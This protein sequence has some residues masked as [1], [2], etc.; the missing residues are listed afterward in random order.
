MTITIQ[1]LHCS[2]SNNGACGAHVTTAV[3]LK[4]VPASVLRASSIALTASSTPLPGEEM[5]S[6]PD[7]VRAR[8]PPE[9]LESS[10]E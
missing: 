3:F 6:N 9:F 1:T 10:S 8:N 7:P 5:G 2:R 4:N